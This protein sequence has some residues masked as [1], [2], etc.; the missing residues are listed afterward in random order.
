LENPS[1]FGRAQ[2]PVW[3]PPVDGSL[4]DRAHRALALFQH[5]LSLAMADEIR[6]RGITQQALAAELG[7]PA[8]SFGKKLRGHDPLFG[9]D[10]FAWVLHLG[11]VEV[12]PA[13]ANLD[14][15]LP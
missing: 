8:G 1:L 2:S 9:E 6:E 13:P 5:Q 10:L 11:R 15:L 12:W 14:E 4:P 3:L 7:V